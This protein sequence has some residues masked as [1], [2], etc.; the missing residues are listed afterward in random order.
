MEYNFRPDDEEF[1]DCCAKQDYCTTCPKRMGCRLRYDF[2]VS[3]EKFEHNLRYANSL[4]TSRQKTIN[5]SR[6]SRV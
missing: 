6:C 5:A 1:Y 2:Y 4:V 3:D